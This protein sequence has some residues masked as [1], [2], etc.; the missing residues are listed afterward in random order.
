MIRLLLMV[1]IMTAGVTV[2]AEQQKV[3]PAR[4]QGEW[5]AQL[6]YCG[7]WRNDSRLRISSDRIWFFES[8][9]PIRAV[10]TQGDFDLALI[11]ELSGEGQV[12]LSYRHFR[13]SD[14]QNYLTDVSEAN[15]GMVR[16]RCPN[17]KR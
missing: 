8:G 10:V 13:L 9:G 16:Y 14:N 15:T 2:A 3:V 12:W 6:K 4:F 5:N 7:T 17:A 11:A 1:L